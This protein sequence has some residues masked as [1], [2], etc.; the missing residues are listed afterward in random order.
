MLG[1]EAPGTAAFHAFIAES[2]IRPQPVTRAQVLIARDAH[3]RFGKGNHPAGLNFGDCFAYAL[4]KERD[5]R[6]CSRARTSAG[7][8]YARP[9]D[10]LGRGAFAPGICP[11]VRSYSSA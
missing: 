6:S 4:A 7:R 10:H 3:R 9:C 5:L 8:T 1:R 2:E 11:H